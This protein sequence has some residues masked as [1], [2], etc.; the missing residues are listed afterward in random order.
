MGATEG[1]AAGTR[2]PRY[3]GRR[4]GESLGHEAKDAATAA[5]V[6]V[7]KVAATATTEA[8]LSALSVATIGFAAVLALSLLILTW[9]FLLTA[10]LWLAVAAG[11]PIAAGLFIAAAVNLFAA[12]LF[13]AWC[14][15]L[16]RNIGF[17]RTLGLMFP[18]S[19]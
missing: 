18:G 12:L 15:R 6:H 5:A 2:E 13:L 3:G 19:R 7:R 1:N 17:P 8:Q 9:F 14:R 4:G 11:L 16:V 10:V